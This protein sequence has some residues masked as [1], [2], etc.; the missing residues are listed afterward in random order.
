MSL[1]NPRLTWVI[2]LSVLAAD[3]FDRLHPTVAQDCEET[4]PFELDG[5]APIPK[6]GRLPEKPTLIVLPYLKYHIVFYW[7]SSTFGIFNDKVGEVPAHCGTFRYGSG[8]VILEYHITDG[9]KRLVTEAY[10]VHRTQ[11]TW[12]V[13]FF[14]AYWD[15]SMCFLFCCSTFKGSMLSCPDR[16]VGFPALLFTL[17]SCGS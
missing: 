16:K 12:F 6:D 10:Y 8:D 11:T 17:P 1:F 15:C 9:T 3:W 14:K 4:P 2:L 13:T 7:N 5:W